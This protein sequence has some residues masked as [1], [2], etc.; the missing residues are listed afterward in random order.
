MKDKNNKVLTEK[1]AENILKEYG[2]IK[3]E[4]YKN[5]RTKIKCE[6]LETKYRYMIRI[7]ALKNGDKPSL[8]GR[9]NECNFDYNISLFV[10]K[11]F[12]NVKYINY[13]FITKSNK[14]IHWLD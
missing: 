3:L 11:N 14:K 8:W 13:K 6:N 4:R 12:K 7:G 1:Q 5:N 2:Y 10:N 9:V